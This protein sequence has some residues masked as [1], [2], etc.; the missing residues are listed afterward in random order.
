[1]LVCMHGCT[2]VEKVLGMNLVIAITVGMVRDRSMAEVLP[3][4]GTVVKFKRRFQI[5]FNLWI[6][7]MD[8]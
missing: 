4:P 3:I 5:P 1:M 6:L 2:I 8:F 7:E